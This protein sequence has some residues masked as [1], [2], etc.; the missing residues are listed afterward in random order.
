MGRIK[1]KTVTIEKL[2]EMQNGNVL[3]DYKTRYTWSG[4]QARTLVKDIYEARTKDIYTLGTVVYNN[5]K[6]VDGISRIITLS[7][8][9]MAIGKPYPKLERTWTPNEIKRIKDN[10]REIKKALSFVDLSSFTEFLL[11]KCTVVLIE[12]ESLYDSFSFFETGSE[13]GQEIEPTDLLKAYHLCSMREKSEDAK[14]SV[15][16]KWENLG[17]KE[18]IDLFSL[19][20]PIINW[21][22]G[23]Y[24]PIFSKT[25]VSAF[26]GIDESDDYPFAKRILES[27]FSLDTTIVNGEMFFRRCF[28]FHNL[29]KEL[30]EIIERT[31]PSLS[32]KIQHLAPAERLCYNLF[33]ILSF[34]MLDR[35]GSSATE[36][37]LKIIFKFSFAPIFEDLSISWDKINEYV[38]SEVSILKVIE[39]SLNPYEIYS[40]DFSNKLSDM[41]NVVF[42]GSGPVRAIDF[43][44][45]FDRWLK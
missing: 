37:A 12:V 10:L 33:E 25:S 22:K 38:L 44:N 7:L 17:K 20:Y 15:I 42:R 27:Q 8:V 6:L 32:S 29:K 1:T 21:T 3:P 30:E 2:M 24:S 28:Y 43:D 26:E 18:L 23:K 14:Y 11:K 36:K 19:W 34:L 39:Y 41:R 13:R 40:Y 45:D 35:F 9:L 31:I 16:T 4:D 5:G